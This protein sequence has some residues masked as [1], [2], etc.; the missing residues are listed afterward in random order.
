MGAIEEASTIGFSKEEIDGVS[1]VPL[2]QAADSEFHRENDPGTAKDDGAI[3]WHV[4]H[5]KHSAPYSAII[6]DNHKYIRYWEDHDSL[7][8]RR[9]TE[10][11]FFMSEKELYNLQDN[12]SESP[13]KRLTAVHSSME[14][15]L[16]STLL[17]WLKRV[18]AKMPTAVR[19]ENKQGITQAWY[20][21]WIAKQAPSSRYKDPVEEAIYNSSPGDK[22]TIYPGNLT[23]S[24]ALPHTPD[25]I[26]TQSIHP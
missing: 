4:P 18:D 14:A 24:I 16:E 23:D 11:G 15:E 3:F 25:G 17:D 26:T 22:I 20:S 12:L 9:E 10:D 1:L 21:S 5:Y 13:Q 6:K 8:S 19:R 2:L 7:Q